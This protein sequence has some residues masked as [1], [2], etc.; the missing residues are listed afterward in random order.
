MMSSGSLEEIDLT[1]E[2]TFASDEKPGLK[3]T[4][5]YRY[6]QY[7]GHDHSV[8]LKNGTLELDIARFFK[9][10]ELSVV[11]RCLK[12]PD[13]YRDDDNEEE[14]WNTMFGKYCD[15]CGV[16]I[17]DNVLISTKYSVCEMCDEDMEYTR[18]PVEERI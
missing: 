9:D 15:C 4:G 1:I 8:N 16:N 3:L 17:V 11:P 5:H 13:F 12:N 6:H 7:N 18:V 10:H 2:S 14:M